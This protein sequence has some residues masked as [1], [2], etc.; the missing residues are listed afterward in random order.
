MP[1]YEYTCR[2]CGATFELVR[3]FH[4]A[5]DVECP[6]CHGTDCRKSVSLFSASVARGG[7]AVESCGPT[8][9]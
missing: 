2:H 3:S 1:I 4:D 8:G 5:S 9:G 6:Q 7:S